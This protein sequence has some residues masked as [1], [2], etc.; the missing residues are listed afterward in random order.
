MQKTNGF[1]PLFN[2]E[3][4]FNH[5][6]ENNLPFDDQ[7]LY[8]PLEMILFPNTSFEVV[9]S[10]GKGVLEIKYNNQKKYY[11]FEAFLNFRNFFF[12]PELQPM[13]I[14][15]RLLAFEGVPY[16]WGGNWVLENK[17]LLFLSEYFKSNSDNFIKNMSYLF[18]GVD[19]SGLLYAAC[20]G[21]VPRNTSELIHFG[22]FIHIE[23]CSDQQI[24]TKVRPLDLLVWKGHVLIFLDE[25]KLIESRGG[26]GCV[27]V[28][29]KERLEEIRKTRCPANQLG[30]DCFY[31]KRWLQFS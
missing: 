20:L 21:K 15:E 17:E 11:I 9:N 5:F 28:N 2:D 1:I 7:G 3:N 26:R 8:R 29:A 30:E 6:N 27:V 31:I 23:G 18:S 10:N 19:C 16:V 25:T 13:Q 22:D 24:C 4:I 12:Y 14:I